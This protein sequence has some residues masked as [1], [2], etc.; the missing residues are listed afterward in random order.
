MLINEVELSIYRFLTSG[1]KKPKSSLDRLSWGFTI[2]LAIGAFNIW[3]VTVTLDRE[4]KYLNQE[5]KTTGRERV[6]FAPLNRTSTGN[7]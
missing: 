7:R 5:G 3:Q 2:S 4:D 1:A 6:F